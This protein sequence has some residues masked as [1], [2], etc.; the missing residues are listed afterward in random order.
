MSRR[1]TRIARSRPRGYNRCSNASGESM[2]PACGVSTLLLTG[3]DVRRLLPMRD[4][5]AALGR[6]FGAPTARTLPAGILGAHV[7]D[8]GFHVKTAGM[9]GERPYFAAK[10][11]ANFPSNPARNA[12]PTVQGVLILFDAAC[13]RPLAIMDSA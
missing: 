11:N 12:L 7:A 9:P 8:G 3:T 5:I 6:A 4:C 2:H 13:G 1:R 10:V